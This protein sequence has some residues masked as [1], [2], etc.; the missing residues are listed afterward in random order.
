MSNWLD[1]EPN[2]L[3]RD[4]VKKT[5]AS[6]DSK[7]VKALERDEEKTTAVLLCHV[8]RDK[9]PEAIYAPPTLATTALFFF[10]R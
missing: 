9:P 2:Y 7:P 8:C 10:I 6:T 1:D 4:Q 5:P 3:V